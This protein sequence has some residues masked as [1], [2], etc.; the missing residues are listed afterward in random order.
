MATLKTG[1]PV[2]IKSTGE[3]SVI[4]S[5]EN[6]RY[7]LANKELC[8]S[9]EITLIKTKPAPKKKTTIRHVSPF[10]SVL[11]E[12]YKIIHLEYLTNNP[13]CG[14]MLHECTG[15]SS[16]IH[17]KYKRTGFFLVMDQ[18]FLPICNNCHSHITMNSELAINLGLSISRLSE[19]PYSFSDRTMEL[20]LEFE[21]K[22]P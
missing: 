12:I 18:L 6:G 11:N 19:I 3:P 9:H 7:L 17:H 10:Q 1:S 5:I 16:Q 20:L 22:L 13:R 21:V 2:I 8:W 15:N 14:A 4:S